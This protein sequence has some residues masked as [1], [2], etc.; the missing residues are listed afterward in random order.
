MQHVDK[1][2]PIT[3]TARNINQE[4]YW[5]EKCENEPLMKNIKKEQHGNSYKQAYIE[6]YIQNLLEK[7][8]SENTQQLLDDLE[9]VRYE[10]FSLKITELQHFSIS[11]LFD[12]LP[13][14]AFL[15][16]TY[17]AKHVHMNYE[18]PMF[19]MK[20][21]DALNFSKCL[22]T[23]TSLTHLALPGNLIDDD[24]TKI[25]VQNL[26]LNKT[27]SQLD[28]AHNKIGNSGARKIAKYILQTQILTHLNLNDNCISYD[29]SR[30]LAQALKVNKSLISLEL[31]LNRLDDKAG[32]KLCLDLLNNNSGLE[33]IGLSAN[34][35]GN[36]FCE[37]LAEFVNVNES[38][39]SV[40]VS[41][42]NIQES[43]A[44]TL[45]E[46]L[47]KNPNITK[48]DVRMN[49]FVPETVEAINEIVMKNFLKQQNI[50]YFKIP[51]E[52]KCLSF[53]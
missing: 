51:D 15:Q 45:M 34:Q 26:M 39:Q 42:N 31:A 25:L 44:E 38:I 23:T 11:D 37:S 30:F 18:R 36:M 14:L 32:S 52:R 28:L 12:H 17:G 35:L 24:L 40:D 21:S 49:E 48:I 1:D 10:V 16:L 9:A 5:Q 29:G 53:L 19:G 47:E 43:N 22:R 7:L 4:F 46:S 6:V 3:V 8:K 41:C 2:L 13:N 20:M 50:S 27:I 33:Y